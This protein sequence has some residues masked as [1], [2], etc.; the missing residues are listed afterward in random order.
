MTAE[1]EVPSQPTAN[2]PS[3]EAPTDEAPTA[4]APSRRAQLTRTLLIVGILLVVFVIILPRYVDYQ[5]VLESFQSLTWQQI[6]VMTI[7]GAIGWV[8]SGLVFTALTAGLGAVRGTESYLIL[9]GIGSSIPAGPFNMGVVWVVQRGWGIPNA[10]ASTAIGLYG[11][12]DILGRLFLPILAILALVATG[13]LP[14][15]GSARTAWI[16]A[17]ISIVAFF[18]AGGAILL[19]VRSERLAIAAAMRLQAY[20][21]AV[22]RR[23]GR[24]LTADVVTAI[25]NFRANLGEVIRTRGVVAITVS[26]ASKVWWSIVL[27]VAL[28]FCG[29]PADVLSAAVVFAVF[30]LV[31]VITIIPIAPG[32]AGVPE[33]L[34]ISA[35]TAIAGEQYTNQISAGVFLYRMYQWFLPIPLAWI[36]LKVA[37]RGR[38][39]LPGT[40][41]LRAAAAGE[42]I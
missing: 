32:G 12:V 22:I 6:A 29:V 2:A 5:E 34:F 9:A 31:F 28:R 3:D 39:M 26:V 24:P 13:Q 27:T 42:S 30:G 35:F 16:I 1:G 38:P 4:E 36:L 17:V 7:L 41:E 19:I 11:I 21:D 33:L 40:H 10:V 8:S 23:L 18:V 25:L 37:R 20:T 15:D 14:D